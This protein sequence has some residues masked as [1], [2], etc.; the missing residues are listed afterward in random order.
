M[1]KKAVIFISGL[2]FLFSSVFCQYVETIKLPEPKKSGGMSLNKALSLRQSQRSFSDREPDLKIISNLLWAANGVNRPDGGRTVP[3]ARSW[4]PVDIYVVKADG[5]YL[6]E[7]NEHV[8]LKLGNEDYRE[9]AGLQDFVKSAPLN[10]VYI[11][12]FD[13]MTGGT[14]EN[15]I[16]S[17]AADVG[18]ISQ[19]VYLYC[20]SVKLSTVV[21]GQIDKDKIREV[22]NLRPGQHPLLAQTIGYPGK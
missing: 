19:N 1:R 20:A 11:A 16:F 15:R 17:S 13:R 8:L 3:S 12:D 22:F 4:R 10:L 6:Y 7:P 5:W 9:Y 18:F 2:L 14:E 21:R